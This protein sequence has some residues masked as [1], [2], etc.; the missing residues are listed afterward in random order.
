METEPTKYNRKKRV[1]SQEEGEEE[2]E[3]EEGEEEEGEEEEG[4]EEEGEEST[5]LDSSGDERPPK[6]KKA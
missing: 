6:K 1:V 2:G 5:E 3:E 4:E